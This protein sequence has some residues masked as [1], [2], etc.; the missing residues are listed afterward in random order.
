M[1]NGKGLGI[2]ALLVGISGLGLGVYTIVFPQVQV[3][4]TKFGIQ[5]TWFNY[6]SAIYCQ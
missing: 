5:N 4:D 3:I 1:S 2:I 6:D